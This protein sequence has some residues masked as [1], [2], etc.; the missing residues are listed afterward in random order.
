MSGGNGVTQNASEKSSAVA[1]YTAVSGTE[2]TRSRSRKP[3]GRGRKG[4]STTAD[5]VTIAFAVAPEH[6]PLVVG[7]EIERGRGVEKLLAAV[8][9]R[10]HAGVGPLAKRE[11]EPR[12]D[13]AHAP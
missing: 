10:A 12:R 2:S 7:Q 11:K 6:E 8:E 9:D 1:Q 4:A 5:L 13:E 3:S